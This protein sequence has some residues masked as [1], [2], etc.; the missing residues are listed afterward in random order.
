MNKTLKLSMFLAAEVG[1]PRDLPA[2][3]YLE[4]SHRGVGVN[5][6]QTWGQ[7]FL[8]LIGAREAPWAN[9]QLSEFL[10]GYEN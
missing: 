2:C 5:P 8:G 10:S 9:H 4:V 1:A 7:R 3:T 6:G